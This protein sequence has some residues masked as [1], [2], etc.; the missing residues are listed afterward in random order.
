MKATK[1]LERG[2]KKNN[3]NLLFKY[4][5]FLMGFSDIFLEREAGCIVPLVFY[6]SI[7]FRV[8]SLAMSFY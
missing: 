3:K 8:P 2:G 6:S 1:G 7:P 5:Y 4:L